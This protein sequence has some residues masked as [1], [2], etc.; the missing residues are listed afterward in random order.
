ML[1]YYLSA[2]MCPAPSSLFIPVISVLLLGP[3][4]LLT[5]VKCLSLCLSVE[6]PLPI[7]RSLS[8]SPLFHMGKD[9]EGGRWRKKVRQVAGGGHHG[10]SFSPPSP[11]HSLMLLVAPSLSRVCKENGEPKWFWCGFFLKKPLSSSKGGRW[12]MCHHPMRHI[13]LFLL[14]LHN[15]SLR[16]PIHSGPS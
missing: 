2:S 6:G 16:M 7:S 13:F 8:Q 12:Y 9:E 4:P 15:N 10:T 1:M 14:K 5:V 3:S 11:L